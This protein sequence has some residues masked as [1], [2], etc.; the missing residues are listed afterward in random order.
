MK[1]GCRVVCL[2]GMILC[3]PQ[4]TNART[5]SLNGSWDFAV[6]SSACCTI[7]DVAPRMSWRTA[8]VPLSWQA[9]FPDLRDYQGVAWYRKAFTLPRLKRTEQASICFGA[10]D[11]LSAVYVNGI[12]VGT[13]E[14]GYTPFEFDIRDVI[15]PGRNEVI[16]RVVDPSK[17]GNGTEGVNYM[18]IPH[19]KQSWY[20][21]TSGIW[22][23]VEIVI[24][25]DRYI[26]RVHITPTVDGTVVFD[27]QLVGGTELKGPEAVYLS[28][29]DPGGNK[30]IELRKA[31]PRL[32]KRLFMQAHV[33]R[34]KLWSFDAPHLY[35][36]QASLGRTDTVVESFGFRSI[37][38]KT[39]RLLL[40]GNPFFLIGALDQDFY[41][42]TI[43]STPSE[44]YLRDEMLKAKKIGLNTLR[45]HIKVPDP[46]YLKV[47]DEVGLLIWYE[48]PN[49]DAFTSEAGRRVMTTLEAVLQRDWNHPS[50]AI[51]SLVNESWGL[52]LQRA[53]QRL[54]LKSA[55][56]EAKHMSIGRLVV[57]NSASWGN[58]HMKTDINDYHTYWTIPEHRGEFDKTIADFAHRPDWLF[59]SFGDAEQTMQEP[60]VLSEFGNWGLPKL[61]DPAPWWISRRFGNV[62]VAFPQDYQGRFR[63]YKYGETFGSYDLLADACQRAQF[64]ALKYE[65]EQLRMTPE[66]EGYV[67]TEFTDINWESNGLL[68]MWRNVKVY[69]DDLAH[70]QQQ[71][72]VVPR[73]EKYNYWSGDTVAVRVWCSH[74]SNVEMRDAILSWSMLSGESGSTTISAIPAAEATMIHSFQI[75]TRPVQSLERLRVDLQLRLRDGRPVARNYC[76][77]FVYPRM[78]TEKVVTA[79]VYDPGERFRPYRDLLPSAGVRSNGKSAPAEFIISSAIDSS[80]LRRLDRGAVVLCL[81]DTTATFPAPWPFRFVSRESEWYDGNWASNVNW[82]RT[83]RAPF[84]T[85]SF[86]KTMGF[87]ASPVAFPMVVEGIPASEFSDVLAGMFVGWLHLNSAYIVQMRV[88]KGKLILCTLPLGVNMRDNPYAASLF[89]RLAR[90]SISNECEPRM[91]L[92]DEPR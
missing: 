15:R 62:E 82:I 12:Q 88:G 83:E 61:P 27:V 77:V 10:V 70:I 54:W 80:I 34:P 63:E 85:F 66:I 47:A 71:D 65:I 86:D 49:W 22:Q 30:I 16:V 44:E 1:H 29:F 18:H 52:D 6:D 33:E 4:W 84:E 5:L 75:P 35:R 37:E 76:D 57:D 56:N 92:A 3:W 69:G 78:G 60:L 36:V 55:F 58:F 8:Q 38:A 20:V 9:Q 25:P 59:S 11:Y 28:V 51:I 74:Y 79:D 91:V 19:G 13:H 45:C 50:L 48:I 73:P 39:K 21:Q 14:G 17:E 2:G 31:I 23:S 64:V 32:D 42:E 87:E 24:R 26:D 7:T 43:Y 67:I 40:N 90:Y 72:V 89:D 81:V 68:D 41:P 46:R 53:D